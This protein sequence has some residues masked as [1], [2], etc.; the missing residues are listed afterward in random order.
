MAEEPAPSD[1]P[2]EP[3]DGVYSIPVIRMGRKCRYS[4]HSFPVLSVML[5]HIRFEMDVSGTFGVFDG[6]IREC[7]ALERIYPAI[8]ILNGYPDGFFVKVCKR[9]IHMK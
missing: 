2:G 7:P 9:K 6:F 3:E 1:C 8:S 4:I 5:R